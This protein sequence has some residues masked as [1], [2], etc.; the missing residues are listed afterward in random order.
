MV[1]GIA[2]LLSCLPGF[3]SQ[4]VS[5]S[6]DDNTEVLPYLQFPEGKLNFVG[7][8][9]RSKAVECVVAKI[10]MAYG[11]WDVAYSCC[12]IWRGEV[13]ECGRAKLWDVAYSCCRVWRGEVVECGRAKLWDVAYLCCGVWHFEVVGHGLAKLWDVA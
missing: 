5:Y 1:Y 2:M 4:Q 6:D 9:W 10:E 13:V 8:L 3:E 7:C 12:G 11:L